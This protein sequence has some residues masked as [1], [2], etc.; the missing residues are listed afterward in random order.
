VSNLTLRL[1]TALVGI[2]IVFGATYA[3]GGWFL[4]LIVSIGLAAHVEF[5]R[6]WCPREPVVFQGIGLAAGELMVLRVA[7]PGAE[8]GAVVLAIVLLAFTT[9]F[10]ADRRPPWEGFMRLTVGLFYPAF[11]VSSLAEVRLRQG[12][13]VD[14]D[15]AFW[16]TVAL[17]LSIWSNDTCAYA[18]GRWF[19][20][21]PL[22]PA[23]SPKKTWEGALG[24]L[25]GALV[26]MAAVKALTLPSLAWLH[27]VA[28]GLLAGIG[29]EVGDLVESRLKREVGVKDS[30]RMLPGHGGM[31]DRID[32]L[33]FVAPLYVYYL[34]FVARVYG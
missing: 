5:Y 19:G 6:M 9:F 3:G 24:G 21:H 7:I 26:A 1:L 17:V 2:P 15:V 8:V 34:A 13:W 14:A 32:A 33:L 10:F 16:L 27:A 31:L 18:A 30:G 22:A 12:G 25:V 4:A 23:I 29:G 20:R 28:L 11:F